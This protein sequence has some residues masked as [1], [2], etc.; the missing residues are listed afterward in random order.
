MA[1]NEENE[2]QEEVQPKYSAG[3]GIRRQ[4]TLENQ[5][6]DEGLQ[7]QGWEGTDMNL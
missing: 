6:V 1:D 3:V 5:D 4:G 7:R 2:E